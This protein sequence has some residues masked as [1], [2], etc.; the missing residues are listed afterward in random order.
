MRGPVT[1]KMHPDAETDVL[2]AI[3]AA[4]DLPGVGAG[5]HVLHAEDCPGAGLAC[6]CKPVV[7]GVAKTED[8]GRKG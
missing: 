1:L 5:V 2:H 4:T 7:L 8:D 3:D 6:R